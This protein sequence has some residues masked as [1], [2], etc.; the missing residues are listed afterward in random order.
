[1]SGV[2]EGWQVAHVGHVS[3]QGGSTERRRLVV[4]TLG[5]LLITIP[6]PPALLGLVGHLAV[7]CLDAFLL[8]GQRPVHVV[9]LVVQAAG[10]AH[11][12][13]IAVAPPQCGGGGLTVSTTGAGSSGRRQSTFG[14]DEGS[15]LTVHLVVQ[16]AGVTQVVARTIPSPQGGRGGST[17][18]TL[19][20][21]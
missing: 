17:V 19:T 11:G 5:Q 2:A 13:S 16:A 15:V 7:T 8:H 1:M 6:A 3:G 18:D 4:H 12:V 14:L 21:L 10:V 20:P 9:Q